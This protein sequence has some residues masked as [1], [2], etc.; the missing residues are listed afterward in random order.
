[1]EGEGTNLCQWSHCRNEAAKHAVFGGRVFDHVDDVHISE[2]SQ[3]S[4]HLDLCTKH[5]DLISLQY[6]TVNVYELGTCPI[7]ELHSPA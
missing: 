4:D 1:M 2:S 7:R 5:L 6:L 3:P